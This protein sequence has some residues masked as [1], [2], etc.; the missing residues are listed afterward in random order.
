M[1]PMLKEL[2]RPKVLRDEGYHLGPSSLEAAQVSGM[3]L[4]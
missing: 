2:A 4:M 3:S 1:L